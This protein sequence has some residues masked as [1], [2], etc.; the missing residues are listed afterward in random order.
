M[1]FSS[2]LFL[3]LFLPLVLLGNALLPKKIRNSFILLSSLGFYTWGEI[4]LFYVMILSIGINYTF[5]VLVH[6]VK[7]AKQLVLFTGI[8]LNLLILFY[9][10]YAQFFL[11]IL[12]SSF[13]LSGEDALIIEGIHLPIGI[14]F[15][16]FQGISY[17]VDVYRK[18][19][20]PQYNPIDIGLYISLFPQLIA[21]P[22]VR[23]NTVMDQIHHRTTRFEDVYVG[24]K[25]FT[26]G[27]V[28]KVL[29]ANVVAE[30]ADNIFTLSYDQLPFETAWLGIICYAL[31]IFFDFS[32]YSDMAIGLGRML[33][34]HF[35]E[36]FNFPYV[37]KSIKEFWRRWHISLSRWFRDYLYIPLGGSRR[38]LKRT[39][40]NLFVVFLLTG[41]WHGASW[42]FIFWGVF[43]GVFLM[44]EKLGLS[45]VLEKTYTPFQHIYTLLIVLVGWV[46]F[47]VEEFPDALDYLARMIGIVEDPTPFKWGDFMSFYQTL[48]LVLGIIFSVNVSNLWGKLEL[49]AGIH[50][51]RVIQEIK[52]S[53]GL[54]ILLLL[55]VFGIMEIANNTFNPFIY[56]RF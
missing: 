34:F 41:F 27:F 16:T 11:D 15:F 29:I 51:H 33:G 26:I 38:G 40:F 4:E 24:I 9:Y 19:A 54:I 39:Y 23:Y 5:G 46:F 2:V 17:V 48:S 18:Q 13:D 43:H 42:S 53:V 8:G 25:R 32:G 37:S 31:Q 10:K 35:E 47:R 49:K 30:V 52:R 1:V 12:N 44:L 45:K 3:L 21:G 55:F 22:I 14:S 56:F 6:K 7:K 20:K 50:N 36:N 28:K